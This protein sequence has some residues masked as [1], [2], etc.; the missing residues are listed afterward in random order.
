MR[1]CGVAVGRLEQLARERECI[2]LAVR[3][4]VDRHP[5]GE[6]YNQQRQILGDSRERERM[7]QVLG[8][9]GIVAA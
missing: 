5:F 9:A 4:E 3:A 6:D 7:L 1:A 8:R 2:V